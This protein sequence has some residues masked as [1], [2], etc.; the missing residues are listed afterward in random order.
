MEKDPIPEEVR[1]R[2]LVGN[3]RRWALLCDD[4]DQKK[5]PNPCVS[6]VGEDITQS[7][8]PGWDFAGKKS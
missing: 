5:C 6:V 1:A 4:C 8:E 2:V 3:N 7:L